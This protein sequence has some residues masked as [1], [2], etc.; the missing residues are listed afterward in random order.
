MGYEA[1]RELVFERQKELGIF[2]EDAELT[3]L[4]PYAEETERRRQALD[5]RST[6]SGRGTRSP[7]TRSGCSA[8]WPRS[9]PASSRTPT[10]RSGGC[11]TSSRSP[12]SS[13]TRSSCSSPTTARAARAGRT[14]RSTRTSSSTASRTRSRR[15]CSTSTTSARPA[16][17]NHYPVGWAWAFNTPFKMWKRYNFEGGVADPLVVSWP[18]GIAA[19]GELRHQFLHATDIVPTMYDLLGVELPEV[20]KGY[21]QIPLEGVSFRST[22]ESDD[23][24]TPKESGVLLDARLARRLA[25]GLEGRQRPPDDRRLGPLRRATAGSSTTPTTIRPRATTSPP[26]TPRRCKELI[27]HW[28]HL[29]GL[30]NGLPL[31]GQ[32]ARRGARRPDPAAGRAAARPLRLLPGR[33]RGA[34]DRRRS[35][36][37]TAATRSRSR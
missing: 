16:T 27:D 8:A 5:R 9:T 1:Y 35:T 29:A 36:S 26:S 15:T 6:S 4:N 31:H 34:R 22:F 7:T 24:P 10:T 18:K 37:A 3:P 19:K 14:A 23:V 12:A 30:Y 17:Y 2:P 33:G 13:R 32:D 20:V 11:S 25:Q 28:F 21:P